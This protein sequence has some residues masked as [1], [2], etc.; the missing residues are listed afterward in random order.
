MSNYSNQW[1]SVLNG[2]PYITVSAKGIANGLSEIPNDG[3]DFGP[4]TPDTQTYGI[5]EAVNY[6]SNTGTYKVHLQPSTYTW[7][8]VSTTQQLTPTVQVPAG[9]T[10]EGSGIDKTI[11][12]IN[13]STLTYN[14]PFVLNSN[15]RITGMTFDM[16]WNQNSTYSPSSIIINNPSSN[17]EIDHNKFIHQALPWFIQLYATFNS[18]SPPSGYIE[19]VFIHD[20]I[21][22][23]NIPN[24]NNAYESIL[25]SNS[26]YV[27]I[28]N[29]Y[30]YTDATTS[31]MNSGFFAIYDYSRH[32]D[33]FDNLFE[34]PSNA[35]AHSPMMYFSDTYDVHFFN[36]HGIFDPTNTN[37]SM[38]GVFNSSKYV[39]IEGNV[40]TGPLAQNVDGYANFVSFGLGPDAVANGSGGPDGNVSQNS[41]WNDYVVIKNNY[42]TGAFKLFDFSFS[43]NQNFTYLEISDNVFGI[44]RTWGNILSY[45]SQ[46]NGTIIYRNNVEISDILIGA[47]S[48]GLGST[49]FEIAPPSGYTVSTVIVEGNRFPNATNFTSSTAF[50]NIL[51]QNINNL[52]FRD[53]IMYNNSSI[54]SPT[55]ITTWYQLSDVTTPI[56][57]PNYD[58]ASGKVLEQM[59]PVSS[60]TGTTAGTVNIYSMNFLETKKYIIVLSGY[61]NDTATNQTVNFPF[62]F[63]SYAVIITNNT[64][65]TISANTSGI[66]ITTPNN[67][68]THSG[69]VI[70]E[71]Y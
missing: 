52:I 56:A 44:L 13:D 5:Q 32:T 57:G 15:T 64:G 14:V 67:T 65:L 33:I 26:K 66:T 59:F 54:S 10:I 3:A 69:I 49:W 51:L 47:P 4:D 50:N 20:N 46:N 7:L 12:K 55:T 28:Y 70:V 9:V 60:A 58:G 22:N 37:V 71:G 24:G 63:S 42:V 1:W 62:S 45:A 11:I 31:A 40:F 6:A 35:P 34:T 48:V 41:G 68:T 36:N 18:T 21:I 25:V 19:N 38:L 16:A 43:G 23:A 29:N 30:F 39:Y 61:E 8:A 27:K 17:I 53:N 2:K